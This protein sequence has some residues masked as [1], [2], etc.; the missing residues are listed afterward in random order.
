MPEVSGDAARL[1]EPFY[2]IGIRAGI[3]RV[4]DDVEYREQ[5][6]ARGFVNAEQ[7]RVEYVATQYADLYREIRQTAGRAS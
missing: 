1:V 4:I 7:F 6:V 3:R 2:V 5:L